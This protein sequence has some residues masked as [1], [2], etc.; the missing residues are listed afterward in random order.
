MLQR[1]KL[2]AYGQVAWF[3]TMF[4]L[5]LPKG[6]DI[7]L[8]IVFANVPGNYRGEFLPNLSATRS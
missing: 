7:P 6:Y 2:T 5:D 8:S 4:R 3:R 1:E